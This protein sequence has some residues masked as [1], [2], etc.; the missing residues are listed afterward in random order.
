M[1]RTAPTV[2]NRC[3]AWWSRPIVSIA[4]GFSLGLLS[5]SLVVAQDTQPPPPPASLVLAPNPTVRLNDVEFDV[6][7]APSVDPPSGALVVTY[8]WTAGFND[9]QGASG[10][11]TATTPADNPQRWAL[12]MPYHVSGQ[13]MVGFVC[14][15]ARDDAG[16][17]S[18]ESACAPV[19]VPARPAAP[20]L[21]ASLRL[22]YDEPNTNDCSARPP[23][24]ALGGDCTGTGPTTMTCPVLN[25]LK[26]IRATFAHPA[27]NSGTPWEM[28]FVAT[29]PGGGQRV[30]T[31]PIVVNSNVGV[32][33]VFARSVDTC[34]NL[35]APTPTVTK[36]LA[37][38]T[39]YPGTS[40][41][42]IIAQP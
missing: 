32:L 42:E 9:G 40:I 6:Q 16:N 24:Y 15:H 5:P 20:A 41:L 29:N 2:S 38:T 14:L 1:T 33:S 30:V 28:D 25:D 10:T 19:P 31:S 36:D 39:P 11:F 3:R 18:L 37:T 26:A 22:E 12:L 7:F 17:L 35:S 27:L 8:Q 23:P 4:L 21:T 34:G 13:A